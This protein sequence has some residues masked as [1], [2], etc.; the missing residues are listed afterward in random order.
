MLKFERVFRRP[1]ESVTRVIVFG[2][3]VHKIVGAF[4]NVVKS[5]PGRNCQPDG[6]AC[7]KFKIGD[8]RREKSAGLARGNEDKIIDGDS[9]GIRTGGKGLPRIELPGS[10]NSGLGRI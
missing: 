6:I 10:V 7:G 3:P 9:L 5:V 1:I 4:E 8:A 2:V